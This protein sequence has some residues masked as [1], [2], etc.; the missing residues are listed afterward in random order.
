VQ[1][2]E[3]VR[4]R[5]SAALRPYVVSYAGYRQ[6]GLR[7]AGHRGLPSPYLTLIL[8]IDEPLIIAAHPDPGQAPGR[9]DA[10]LGGLHLVP[11]LI[12]HHGAQSGMQVAVHPLGCRALFG[13]PAA[14]LAGVD[15]DLT[16]VLPAATV[17]RLRDRIGS[18][19]TWPARFAA[20]DEEL[21]RLVRDRAD[22]HP[23]VAYAFDRVVDSGGTVSVAALA[24]EVGWTARHLTDRF[25]AE[26]GLRPKEAARVTRFD[27]ARREL[28]AGVRP[29]EVAALAGYFDQAHLNREFREFA[30]VPPT[31]WLADE[32]GFLQAARA[33]PDQDQG[34][35]SEADPA[36]AG[37]AHAAGTRRP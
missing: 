19:A 12:T 27:R 31:V 28:S 2:N 23:D 11:A 26:V 15:T 37:V 7:P 24:G 13:R 9:Y 1:V 17:A 18:A 29:A 20:V 30:G 8:T 16:A 32:F 4:A 6:R 25:R 14:E 35:D 21:R 33:A 22:V 34:H 36:T 5:P 3:Y 10:L